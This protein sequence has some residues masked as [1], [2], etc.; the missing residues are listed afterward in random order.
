MRGIA[1]ILKWLFPTRRYVIFIGRVIL[2]W[3]DKKIKMIDLSVLL[4]ALE[5]G[6]CVAVGD[7]LS[8]QLQE[9]IS[10]YDYAENYYHGFLLGL[11]S[12]LQGYKK[13][14]NLE[15]GDGR[16]NI[17]LIPY[18][19][20]LP[21]AIL[22]LKRAKKFTEMEKL[23]KEALQQIDE[24]HYDE[25]LIEEGYPLVLKYGICFCKKSCMVKV[26]DMLQTRQ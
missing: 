2:L 14:S 24:K 11:L 20:Q 21:A 5:S 13:K 19:E 7:F 17:I 1:F 12:G 15:S 3:F 8:G 6:D 10:F 23:C 18:D 26:G 4:S 16:Y 25:G 9:S 22:E